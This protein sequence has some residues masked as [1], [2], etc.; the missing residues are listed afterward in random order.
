MRKELL[1]DML[2]VALMAFAS[3]VL[4]TPGHKSARPPDNP[5]VNT[6]PFGCVL[7]P[8]IDAAEA[9]CKP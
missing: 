5:A 3:A 9:D 4:F 6:A 1:M 7:P 2:L 8:G